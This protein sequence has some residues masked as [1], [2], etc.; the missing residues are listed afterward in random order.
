MNEVRWWGRGEG[1]K[2]LERYKPG[3]DGERK[4]KEEE[5]KRERVLTSG[6]RHWVQWSITRPKGLLR[7][8]GKKFK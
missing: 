6:G 7:V 4:K 2:Q 5:E 8:N 3:R 1:P